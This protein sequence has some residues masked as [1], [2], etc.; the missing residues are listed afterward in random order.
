MSV[1]EKKEEKL[2]RRLLPIGALSASILAIAS[3]LFVLGYSNMNYCLIGTNMEND[4]LLRF[5]WAPCVF[6]FFALS[7]FATGFGLVKSQKATGLIELGLAWLEGASSILCF[8]LYLHFCSVDGVDST[9]PAAVFSLICALMLLGLGAYE[10]FVI[11]FKE[12]V[13][14]ATKESETLALSGVAC[15][16]SAL[17]LAITLGA[18]SYYDCSTFPLFYYVLI[19]AAIFMIAGISLFVLTF[20]DVLDA[21]TKT[22][23]ML[24]VGI[25]LSAM[26]AIGLFIALGVFDATRFDY[27]WFYYSCLYFTAG[28]C[29]GL[30]AIGLWFALYFYRAKGQ[31]KEAG[32][33]SDD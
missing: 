20:L 9:L 28:A 33:L 13:S 3:L 25:A 16:G 10:S 2:N 17:F 8:V 11:A 32:S 14:F 27:R 12:E 7:R 6:V 31:S 21:S 18:Y 22:K 24:A 4:S 26:N 5:W 1:F 15:L 30:G 23:A 29:L 19:L